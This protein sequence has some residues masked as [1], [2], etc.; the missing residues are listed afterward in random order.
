[1][2]ELKVTLRARK[3]VLLGSLGKNVQSS[4]ID[5]CNAMGIPCDKKTNVIFCALTPTIPLAKVKDFGKAVGIKNKLPE[6]FP[7]QEL[8]GNFEGDK[9]EYHIKD[10]DEVVRLIFNQNATASVLDAQT[11]QEAIN[12]I[13]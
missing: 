2:L 5:W 1:M 8:K 4:T 6:Y 12:M 11:F 7:L 3:A 13:K 10:S 9:K